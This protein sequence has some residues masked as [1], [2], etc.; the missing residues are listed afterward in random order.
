MAIDFK[1]RLAKMNNE[2]KESETTHDTFFGKIAVG[3]YIAKLQSAK[4][5]EN[6]NNRLYVQR[7]HLIVE[8]GQKGRIAFDSIQL[9]TTVGLAFFRH[10]VDALGLEAPTDPGE[11]PEYVEHIL[12]MAPTVEIKVSHP[13]KFDGIN[14]RVVRLVESD[15]H[16]EPSSK[17]GIPST[18]SKDDSN[19]KTETPN[20]GEDEST[21]VLNALIALGAGQGITEVKDCE[22][23]EDAVNLLAQYNYKT[24]ELEQEEIALLKEHGLDDPE[25][26]EYDTEQDAAPEEDLS[27]VTNGITFCEEYGIKV[28]KD[29]DAPML[30]ELLGSYGWERADLNKEEIETLEALEVELA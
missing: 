3:N 17:K 16:G 13:A 15:G 28:P 2:Y 19:V 1:K 21:E 8:G 14:V 30:K 9:E 11:I 6:S 26:L 23:V 25:T 22:S 10:W 20:D 29:A 4:I 24:S 27:I 7:E 5:R 12:Q 18:K